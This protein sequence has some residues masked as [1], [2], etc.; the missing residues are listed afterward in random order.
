MY[1]NYS[2]YSVHVLRIT[3]QVQVPVPE[4]PQFLENP[5]QD[6]QLLYVNRNDEQVYV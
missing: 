3:V 6:L 2:L 5:T 1:V 4:F